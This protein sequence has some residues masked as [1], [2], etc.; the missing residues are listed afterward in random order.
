M[1]EIKT[2]RP[3]QER[4][5]D[6]FDRSKLR[7]EVQKVKPKRLSGLRKKYASWALGGALALG[8]LG[9]PMKMVQNA[10]DQG[11]ARK[12]SAAETAPPPTDSAIQGDLKDAKS[13][14]DQVA[15]G[16]QTVTKNVADGVAAAAQN[17]LQTVAEA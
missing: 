9:V 14:A 4:F 7:E 3:Y 13:L 10:Q 17:P 1:P 11:G 6:G 15:T 8:G 5:L 2:S 16:V 12:A